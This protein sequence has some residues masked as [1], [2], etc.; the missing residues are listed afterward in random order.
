MQPLPIFIGYDHRQ[1]VALTTLAHS[2]YSKASKP[3][4]II[5]LV[6]NQLPL[7]RTG[8]TPF[9]FT[10]FLVPYLCDYKGWGLFLDIDII[11]ND[12]IVKIFSLVDDRYSVFVSKNEKR[13]EWASVMLFNNAKCTNLTP[14]YVE[15]AEDL[16]R[17]A[18][19]K[20]EE[21]GDLP[22]E[23]N[24]LVG[25]DAP[26]ESP[27]LIHYTQ[28]IPAFKQTE[29]SEHAG[30]WRENHIKA[31]SATSWEDL[32]GHSVHAA[33]LNL[34]DD[35]TLKVPRYFLHESGD[36]VNEGFKEKIRELAEAKYGSP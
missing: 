35:K 33:N 20:D 7:K 1:P 28:G 23:W 18:W 25:Y 4:S 36:S 29:T 22:P 26:R 2:I 17:I 11:L 21:I 15:T 34:G 5:P 19:C 27:S 9:T 8:L 6:L 30:L 12:D 13:F 14:E 31:N 24:H 32:M 10:R 16:H 3:V